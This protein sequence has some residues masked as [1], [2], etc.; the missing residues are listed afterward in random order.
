MPGPISLDD[1]SKPVPKDVTV[2]SQN[3]FLNI[4]STTEVTITTSP[5][6]CGFNEIDEK[7]CDAYEGDKVYTD[8]FDQV[9]D[10]FSKKVDCNPETLGI[11]WC[12]GLQTKYKK[13]SEEKR[14]AFYVIDQNGNANI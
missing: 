3:S 10:I 2:C 4:N 12:S 7:Y 5:P 14:H 11:D 13:L 9:Q 6:R 1:L 8:F